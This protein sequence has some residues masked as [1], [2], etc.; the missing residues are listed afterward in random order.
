[1]GQ[2]DVQLDFACHLRFRR[3]GKTCTAHAQ[4]EREKCRTQAQTHTREMYDSLYLYSAQEDAAFKPK[5]ADL[6]P[7]D[8]ELQP[9][10][11]AA[12]FY[13]ACFYRFGVSNAHS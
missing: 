4:K 9:K 10:E 12:L 11:H 8:A 13:K 6:Q 1:M 2:V 3:M 5:D 7:K